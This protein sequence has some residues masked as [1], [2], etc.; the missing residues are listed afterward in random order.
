MRQKRRGRGTDDEVNVKD[1]DQA[2][3]KCLDSA[4]FW[5]SC[6]SGVI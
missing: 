5:T 6:Q 4:P 2:S 1:A 3:G